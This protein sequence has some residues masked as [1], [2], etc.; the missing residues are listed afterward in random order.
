MP[1]SLARGSVAIPGRL[2]DVS[3]QDLEVIR[4]HFDATNERDF[5][6]AMSYYDDD[7]VLLIE[8]GFLN[9]GTFEGKQ[10]VGE[11]FGDWFRAFGSDYRFEIT[12]ARDLGRGLVFMHAKYRGSGRASGAEVTD[13]RSYLYRVEEGRIVRVQLFTTR[14]EAMEAASRPEW[15]GAQTD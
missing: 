15:S 7:V 3:E 13:E 5:A 11:W 1:A 12:D 10:E 2:Q 6:R 14:E 8:E 9:S 4:E